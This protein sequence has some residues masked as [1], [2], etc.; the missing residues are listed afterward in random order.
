M[1]TSYRR[2]L[3]G[4]AGIVS[5]IAI[6][7]TF[8]YSKS[9]QDPVIHGRRLSSHLLAVHGPFYFSRGFPP[10]AY[11]ANYLDSLS[12]REVLD[13]A[14]PEQKEPLLSDWLDYRIPPWRFA[15]Q[16]QVE[17]VRLKISPL[18]VDR[19][20]IAINEIQRHPF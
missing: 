13:A 14:S 20:R 1:R 15:L 3:I 2:A 8:L 4:A 7:L 11:S 9:L 17:R 12:S 16:K 5:V 10:R 6:G 19:K 18:P